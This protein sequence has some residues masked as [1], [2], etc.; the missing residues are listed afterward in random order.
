MGGTVGLRSPHYQ[1]RSSP[2]RAAEPHR[3]SLLLIMAAV[4]VCASLV[5]MCDWCE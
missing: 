2:V 1:L 4:A 5:M 3:V